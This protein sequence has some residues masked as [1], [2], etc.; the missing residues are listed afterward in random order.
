MVLLLRTFLFF[1]RK[2]S[3]RAKL[4]ANLHNLHPDFPSRFSSGFFLCL[5]K[6]TKTAPQGKSCR[7]V[8]CK[9]D[10]AGQL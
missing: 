5:E 6:G 2:K 8:I 1:E 9:A 10:E 7:G 3:Q 4:A